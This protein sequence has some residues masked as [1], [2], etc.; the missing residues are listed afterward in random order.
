MR[1]DHDYDMGCAKRLDKTRNSPSRLRVNLHG[2]GALPSS[3]TLGMTFGIGQQANMAFLQMG[4][5]VNHDRS[6]RL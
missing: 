2:Y 5:C 1:W 3:P 4:V 6:P